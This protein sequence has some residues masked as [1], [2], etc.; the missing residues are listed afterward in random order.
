MCGKQLTR[1][2]IVCILT[3]E[4]TFAAAIKHEVFAQQP[5]IAFTSNKSKE[6]MRKNLWLYMFNGTLLPRDANPEILDIINGMIEFL[7]GYSSKASTLDDKTLR[8]I[9]CKAVSKTI[10]MSELGFELGFWHDENRHEPILDY[11]GRYPRPLRGIFN[12]NGTIDTYCLLAAA[13]AIGDDSL[14]RKILAQL[15]HSSNYGKSIFGDILTNS[16]SF[17]CPEV[18]AAFSDYLDSLASSEPRLL[19]PVDQRQRSRASELLCLELFSW[20]IVI[21]QAMEM[22]RSP[23]V[24]L[25]LEFI[26]KYFPGKSSGNCW[27]FRGVLQFAIDKCDSAVVLNYL[28]SGSDLTTD[29]FSLEVGLFENICKKHDEHVALRVAKLLSVDVDYIWRNSTTL[30]IAVKHGTAS[31]VA[32]LLDAGA[33]VNGRPAKCVLH[34]SK[35]RPVVVPIDEAIKRGKTDI[36]KILLDHD[37]DVKHVNV[38]HRTKAVYDML[39]E[40]K[41]KQTG[42]F[43]PPYKEKCRRTKVQSPIVQSRSPLVVPGQQTPAAP[44]L[45][46]VSYRHHPVVPSQLALPD[47]GPSA[48]TSCGITSSYMDYGGYAGDRLRAVVNPTRAYPTSHTEGFIWQNR[49]AQPPAALPG[50][51]H[52]APDSR[53]IGPTYTRTPNYPEDSS[54]YPRSNPGMVHAASIHTQEELMTRNR[55]EQQGFPAHV[56]SG[57]QQRSSDPQGYNLSN[58]QPAPSDYHSRDRM[59]VSF[60][61]SS[62]PPAGRFSVPPEYP[63]LTPASRQALAPNA[64]MAGYGGGSGSPFNNPSAG[65]AR[66]TFRPIP[67]TYTVQDDYN[68][69]DDFFAGAPEEDGRVWEGEDHGLGR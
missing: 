12:T 68:S 5:Q 38:D 40:A 13:A 32:A 31:M 1:S 11:M 45:S 49:F 51:V 42:K 65:P 52:S 29:R 30:T 39:R 69:F 18:L 41:M 43:V 17:D 8:E 21:K 22:K 23:W 34:S 4:E 24:K 15:E 20:D 25:L 54:Y 58:T 66:Y 47:Y 10:S 2:G 26:L 46:V 57:L 9:L 63:L 7:R 44:P 59:F 48:T 19:T 36:I 61:P 14:L 28:D 60:T 53:Q 67:G 62:R 64:N 56:H 6:L 50:Y 37:A 16:F 3:L 55:S 33:R 35:M 27:K